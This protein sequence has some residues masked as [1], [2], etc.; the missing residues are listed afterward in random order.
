MQQ[1]SLMLM[2]LMNVDSKIND[3]N[4]Q[5][6]VRSYSLARSVRSL[7]P[8]DRAR[9]LLIHQER[10]AVPTPPNENIDLEPTDETSIST[11]RAIWEEF[12]SDPDLLRAHNIKPH[13]LETLSRVAM[14]GEV[15]CKADLI[16]MLSA[17]RRPRRR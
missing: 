11:K 7:S 16:F 12:R 6:L 3:G 1:K 10:P 2:L 13:E 17:I 9:K 5:F 15:R 4:A 14:L 8:H